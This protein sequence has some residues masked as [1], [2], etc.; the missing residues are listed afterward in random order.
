MKYNLLYIPFVL[1]FLYACHND[2]SQ[3]FSGST[4]KI[5]DTVDYNIHIKP[6]LSDRCFACH[7][8]DK[9]AMKAGLALY[10]AD[11]AYKELKENP[12]HFAI[13]PGKTDQS[14][15]IQRINSKDGEIVMPPPESNLVLNDYEKK[16]ITKWI[17]Q[18][19]VYKPHWSLIPVSKTNIPKVGDE[20][21]IS[22]PIDNFILAKLENMGLEPEKKASKEKLLRRVSFDLI[23]LPPTVKELDDFLQDE[24]DNAYE[25]VVDRLLASPHYG[26]RMASDWLDVSRYA[27]SHG[28]QDDRPRTMWPWRDWVITA[29][30]KNLPYDDFATWQLA[31]DLLPN[32]TYEQKLATGFNRN[33]AITQE[34]G[35]IE[36]EYLTEYAADRVQTFGTAFL[37]LT[38][39]C[40]RCH[41]HKYDP[42][43]QKEHYELFAFFNNNKERGQISYSDLAPTPAIKYENKDLENEVAAIKE[44]LSKEETEQQNF[45]PKIEEQKL[46][47]WY[48]NLDWESLK[49]KGLQ[50]KYSL[51]S[52]E[53]DNM[54]DDVT[55]GFSGTLNY[56]LPL[57]VPIPVSVP[58][59]FDNALLFNGS[60][61]LTIGDVGD[62]EYHQEFSLGGWIKYDTVQER[63]AGI[64]SRRNGEHSNSGYGLYLD[65]DSKLRFQIVHFLRNNILIDVKTKIKIPISEW[66][67]IYGTYDGS[68]KASGLGLFVNGK[69]QEVEVLSDNLEGRSILVGTQLT[70]GNWMIRAVNKSY[71]G[72][73][74]GAIDEISLYNREL[75]PLEVKYLYDQ[76]PQY[77]KDVVYQTYLKSESK[78]LEVIQKKLDSLRTIDTE[79]PY[80][81]VMEELDSVKPAYIL[82]RGV[83]SAHGERVDRETPKSVL[84]FSDELPQNRLG[85]AMWLFDEKNPLTSRVMVNRLWQKVFGQGLVSTPED[86]G[87]QGNLPSHPE[88]L[89]W[90][91]ME[92]M[93]NGWDMKKMLKMMVMSSTYQQSSEIEP[94]K[95]AMDSENIYLARGPYKKLSAEMIR[96]QALASSGLLNEKIGGKWVK[97][98]Q[99][100]GIW[101][102][103][104]NQI[105]ENKYRQGTGADLYRRSIYTY[106]KRTIPVP[107][108]LTFDA[109][110]RAMCTVKRQT[111]S[112][113][114]QSLVLL[115]DPQY[116]EASRILATRLIQSSNDPSDWIDNAFK[117]LVTREPT[118]HES[119]LLMEIYTSELQ[120]FE[121][122]SNSGLE[123]VEIGEAPYPQDADIKTLAALTIVINAVLNLDES[124]HS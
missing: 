24:S 9:N 43:S 28:Y 124:K 86:F 46:K 12:G 53:G 21:W 29:F 100:A 96:D 52:R 45:H 26:E 121:K 27:D 35:V 55:H 116:M 123:I 18:G 74:N 17:E 111:T 66:T 64:L 54:K 70:V 91:S 117:R 23:G 19:A 115:N 48:D 36:E 42:I 25:N 108:M 20:A 30:N 37:G 80:V 40:A 4:G 14:E 11:L 104:A 83:Y 84:P 71:L 98:Y 76:Q 22:N 31:G 97:P 63:V 95:H 44:M 49:T 118:P 89:D 79:I 68:G 106:W 102:E 101:K 39:Q 112:T 114:L 60:N 32:A 75:S 59:K 16:L 47:E 103:L 82:E 107:S 105:G 81:M 113:P 77:D 34:G 5:P 51:D 90:L 56:K 85:L 62:Y 99:P 1:V 57:K 8:P 65:K 93:H 73:F 94:R 7:G 110:E 122:D 6:I 120:R 92:F 10:T 13:V 109:S 88:L 58:G 38:I 50:A 2:K 3:T 69:K 67:N 78:P 72:G 41:D 87:N 15:V 33:H 119:D 61:T